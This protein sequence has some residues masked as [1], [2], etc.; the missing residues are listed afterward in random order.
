MSLGDVGLVVRELRDDLIR[1]LGGA[2]R[3]S[4]AQRIVIEQVAKSWVMLQ[5]IDEWLLTRPLVNKRSRT[6]F[7]VVES[8]QR[9]EDSLI[10]NLKTLGLEKRAKSASL[11][12]YLQNAKG[13]R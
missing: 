12:D 6:V 3:V 7:P 1:D 4:T 10:R 11:P 2:E 13:G 8:R 5:S 9:L